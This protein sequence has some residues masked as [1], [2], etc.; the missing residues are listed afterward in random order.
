[1]RRIAIVNC[2][3][4]GSEASKP[5]AGGASAFQRA[6]SAASR[7]PGVQAIGLLETSE[8]S[9]RI[10]DPGMPVIRERASGAD[11]RAVIDAA[12]RL[13]R[14]FD[15]AFLCWG[16][17]P[18]L[19][20]AVGALI[21]ED[22]SR[23]GSDLA[24]ADG[25]PGGVA[26]ELVAT[27]IMPSLLMLAESNPGPLSRNLGFELVSKDLN[28]FDVETRLAPVDMRSLRLELFCDTRR[29]R[30]VCERLIARGA[31]DEA[32][33]RRIVMEEPLAT[34]SLPAYIQV[35]VAACCPQCCSICPYPLLAGDPRKR[36]GHMEVEDF[37]LIAKQAAEFSGDI[38]MG[39]SLWGETSLHPDP[40]GLIGAAL[41]TEGLTLLIETSGIGWKTK[42]LEA[43]KRRAGKG[44]KDE[45]R[46]LW[47]ASLDSV[48]P[49][50]YAK[51]RGDGF[52]EARAF[53][54]WAIDSFPGK[55]WA[56]ALRLEESEMATEAFYREYSKTGSAI[57]Q[58][59]DHFCGALPKR[60]PADLSPLD[61]NPCWHLKRDLAILING[62]VPRCREDV[63]CSSPIG[64]IMEEGIEAIWEKAGALYEDHAKGIYEG[65][66]G[67]CDEYYTYN[68]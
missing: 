14:G 64:N 44:G 28:S 32:G 13:A 4:L 42:D 34:R 46:L 51:L 60:G 6:L 68:F 67:A 23:Y 18:L 54:R 2:A 53:A 52:E 21:D 17:A 31:S 61:R 24:F 47:I 9:H 30:V 22:F 49:A 29:N 43:I 37:A 40:V 65:M 35:Q 66:C 36:S 16:D 50:L 19:D 10:E 1:M 55:A 56:Q 12:S 48:D 8:G 11:R 38:V 33:I 15:S 63:L 25:Y 7:L 62:D 41:D 58:K 5:L 45:G 3:S 39:I 26:P 20:P 59:H 27:R 57:I